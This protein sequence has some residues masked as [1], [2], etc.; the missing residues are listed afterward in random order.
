MC[1]GG[2]RRSL[3]W[4][5]KRPIQDQVFTQLRLE[6]KVPHIILTMAS[7]IFKK[8]ARHDTLRECQYCLRLV[9]LTPSRKVQVSNPNVRV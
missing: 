6:E 7:F 3:T 5:A 4:R 2:Q 1:C 9:C 8:N